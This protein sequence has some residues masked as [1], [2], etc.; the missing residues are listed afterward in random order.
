MSI[1]SVSVKNI[2]MGTS[3]IRTVNII[4]DDIEYKMVMLGDNYSSIVHIKDF[5][6]TLPETVEIDNFNN[7]NLFGVSGLALE[8]VF[9]EEDICHGGKRELIKIG[10]ENEYNLLL[11][12]I[13]KIINFNNDSLLNLKCF[14]ENENETREVSISVNDRYLKLGWVITTLSYNVIDPTSSKK[15]AKML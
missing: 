5:N 1:F 6:L 4:K 8:R 9:D 2:K 12:E 15:S 7:M 11:N 3:E 14:L 13:K 10:D